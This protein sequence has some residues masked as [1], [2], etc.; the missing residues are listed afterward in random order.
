MREIKFRLIKDKKIVGFELHRTSVMFDDRHIEIYH[1][2][3]GEEWH[4]I[5]SSPWR[6]INYDEKNLFTGLH[7]KNGKEI[8]ESDRCKNIHGEIGIIVFSNGAFWLRYESPHNWDPMCPA[9]LITDK[10]E[11]IGN[12]WEK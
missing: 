1:S 3:D 8:F 7:D 5:C 6:F 10:M 2:V 9:E 12:I 11:I 4:N